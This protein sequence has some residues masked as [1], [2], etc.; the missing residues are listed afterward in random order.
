MWASWKIFSLDPV[1]LLLTLGANPSIADN[2]HGNTPLHWAILAR[3]KTAIN[4]LILKGKAS[5]DIPNFRGETPLKMLQQH[6]GSVWITNKVAEKVKDLTRLQQKHQ[7]YLSCLN[8]LIRISFDR[9]FRWYSMIATPFLVFYLVGLTFSLNTLFIIKLFLLLCLYVI[10]HT[11]GQILFDEHLLTLL[12]L[13]VYGATKF[14]FYVTWFMYIGQAVSM[15]ETILFTMS[16][17]CLWYNF[18]Y[19]W[20][21][22]PGVIIKSITIC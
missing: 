8:F 17:I 2:S 20:R 13:S 22:D 15:Y 21:G 11:I 5:I 9:R 4:T 3:N 1:R 14:W 6:T 16:S 19:S 12:P 10:T 7:K 18:L